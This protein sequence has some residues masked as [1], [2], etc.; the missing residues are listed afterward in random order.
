MLL[1]T[2]SVYLY[3]S[4]LSTF[5]P[6]ILCVTLI[7]DEYICPHFLPLLL[8]CIYLAL[9]LEEERQLIMRNLACEGSTSPAFGRHG[10]NIDAD[11][12]DEADGKKKS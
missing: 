7:H 6:L 10:S 8:S 5:P 2:V 3:Y 12:D 4:H 11:A 9:T 1:S